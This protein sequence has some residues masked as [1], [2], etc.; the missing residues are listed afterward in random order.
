MKI[1]LLST[2]CVCAFL[3]ADAQQSLQPVATDSSLPAVS[4]DYAVLARDANQAV[5]SR[6]RLETNVTTGQISAT[7]N[8]YIELATGLNFWNQTTA[9]WELSRE[10][11]QISKTGYA[12]ATNGQHS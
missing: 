8:S 5:W 10:E 1:L 7:T 3:A 11:F 2:L 12:I 4:A 9:K 6:A